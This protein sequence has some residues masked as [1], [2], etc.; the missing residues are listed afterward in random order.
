MIVGFVYQVV[1]EVLIQISKVCVIQ[2][3]VTRFQLEVI[4][5]LSIFLIPVI[6]LQVLV[7][8]IGVFQSFHD[9][10]DSFNRL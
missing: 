9:S 4:G 8:I 7:K 5:F 3:V 10:G 6:I 2:V 1:V